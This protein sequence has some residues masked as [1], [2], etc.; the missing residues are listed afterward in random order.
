ML[1][2]FN[3]TRLNV[4]VPRTIIA[5]LRKDRQFHTMMC[6]GCCNCNCH[7]TVLHKAAVEFVNV[8]NIQDD[9][10]ADRYHSDD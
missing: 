6:S 9:T 2:G 1:N 10:P 7:L 4:G 8:N 5:L 3:A